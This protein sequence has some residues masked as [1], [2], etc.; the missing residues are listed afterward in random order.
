MTIGLE[1]LSLE[2]RFLSYIQIL[3]MKFKHHSLLCA[4]FFFFYMCNL[5]SAGILFFFFYICSLV[6]MH[7]L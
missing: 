1:F 3:Y 4:F 2:N 7:F 5:H 6:L